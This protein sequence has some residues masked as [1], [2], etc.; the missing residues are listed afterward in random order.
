MFIDII[1]WMI[2]AV[3]VASL[4]RRLNSTGRDIVFG[5]PGIGSLSSV[6]LQKWN[7]LKEVDPDLADAARQAAAL[8]MLAEM[9]LASKFLSL[10]DKSYLPAL[11]ENAKAA[12]SKPL[13]GEFR[14]TSFRKLEDGA[15]IVT[16]GMY[17]GKSFSSVAEFEAFVS[18]ATN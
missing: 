11:L 6:D 9:I 18:G 3:V 16:K 10:N 2:F 12:Y 17:V 1:V 15:V 14:E 4:V 13:I 7:N 5:A 8:G